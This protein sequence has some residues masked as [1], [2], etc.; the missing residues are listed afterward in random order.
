MGCWTS[1]RIWRSCRH[2]PTDEDDEDRGAYELSE[3]PD[4]PDELR[5]EVD[6]GEVIAGDEEV[7][8]DE[9]TS[10]DDEDVV[11]KGQR[12]LEDAKVDK[13]SRMHQV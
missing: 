8:G 7:T 6:V 11:A 9:G 12:H 5:E 3:E 2:R 13:V 1:Y 4:G 10:V